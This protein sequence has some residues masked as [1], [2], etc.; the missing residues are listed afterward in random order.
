MKN[1]KQVLIVRKDLG[2]RKG[3]IAAQASHS[4]LGVIL[5]MMKKEVTYDKIGTEQ[6]PRQVTTNK[7]TLEFETGSDLEEWL[8]TGNFKKICV[9][10]E[11]EKDL[12]FFYNAAK[13]AGLP[14]AL[15]VDSGLTEFHGVKTKTCCSI[16]PAPG[17]EIDK[18]TSELPLL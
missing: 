15:I 7:W 13:E 9:Y 5:D 2:M 3:K 12:V 18:I 1:V 17:D 16:G 6:G 4:S 14:A 11:S 10:V 8:I